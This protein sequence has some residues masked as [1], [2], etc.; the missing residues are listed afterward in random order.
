M[1]LFALFALALTVALP[2]MATD[3][4]DGP[5]ASPRHAASSTLAGITINDPW[6][7]LEDGDDAAVQA[8][9]KAQNA[10]TE[11]VTAAMPMGKTLHQ[12]IRELAISATT[13]AAPR[14]VNGTLFYLRHTPPD[15]QPVLVSQ[16]WPDGEVTVRINPNDGETNTAITGYWPSPDGRYLAWGT[17]EG[18]AELA[19]L[20]IMDLESGTVLDDRLPWAGGGATPQAVAWDADGQGLVY[21]R[22]PPPVNG[23][24]VQQFHAALVHHK[25]GTPANEDKVVFGKDFSRIAEYSLALSPDGKTLAILAKKGDG[26][27]WQLYFRRIGHWQQVLDASANVRGGAWVGNRFVVLSFAD[28]PRGKLV[29]V[30]PDGEQSLLLKQRY[31]ALQRVAPLKNG[32][33]VVRS[34]GADWWVEQFDAEG[35]FVRRL[36]LPDHGIGFGAIASS[37]SSDKA[38][39]TWSGWTTP[40]RWASYDATDG[41]LTPVFKLEPAG[42]YSHIVA[43]HLQAVSTDGTRI[44]VTVLAMDTVHPNGNNPTILYGYGGFDIPMRPGFLGSKLAWLERG[45]VYAVANI[46]GGNE[47][48]EAW[49][50]AGQ[51]LNKQ[52]VFDDF[53]AAALALVNSG[54]TDRDHLGIMGGS[55]GGLLMGSQIVQHPGDYRAVVA[56]VGIYDLVR[57][58]TQFANG[59]YNVPEYGDVRD[60]AQL[61]ATLSWSPLQNVQSDTAYPAVLLTT[62]VNDSRVA[63]WQSR[64]FAAAL[65]S[66]TTSNRPILLLTRMHAGHGIGASF[67]QQVGNTALALTFFADQLGLKPIA[68]EPTAK[69]KP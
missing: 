25:L 42:D 44:P 61:K 64:K 15:P 40:T 18:G 67:S 45:G 32:F 69:D 6:R 7:W 24:P 2:A 60:P 12:R 55:N 52:A 46:R 36:P 8:W 11:K 57:H 19:T 17:A 27:P 3:S 10:W 33:L 68:Q 62:G 9:I 29:A 28:A 14:L 20:H 41:S 58:Q 34:W 31:G 21:V 53:H 13:R 43:H 37:G 23:E 50:A 5:P 49:H 65:Q 51:K 59:K 63:P 56:M 66:A 47:F 4:P 39:I 48:G 16:P 30:T 26:G 22:Y 1:R 35:H 54:W 38:L